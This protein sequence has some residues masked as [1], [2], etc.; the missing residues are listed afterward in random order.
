ML[1][2]AQRA[3]REPYSEYGER[4]AEGANDADGPVSAAWRVAADGEPVAAHA[5]AEQGPEAGGLEEHGGD[6][7]ETEADQ[8]PAAGEA[9]GHREQLAQCEVDDHAE[10]R[11]L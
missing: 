6:G 8:V 10:D 1:G 2:G 7:D 3:A 11:A 5:G 4:A 9:E